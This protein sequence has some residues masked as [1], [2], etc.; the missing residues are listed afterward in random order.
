MGKIANIIDPDQT[1][2]KEQSELGPHSSLVFLNILTVPMVIVI[3]EV[4][5]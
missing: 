2:T 4:N 1:A 3:N 5:I